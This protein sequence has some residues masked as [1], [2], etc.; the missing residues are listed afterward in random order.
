[1]KSQ[2][3]KKDASRGGKGERRDKKGDRK[4]TKKKK[5]KKSREEVVSQASTADKY[6]L[7]QQAVQSPTTKDLSFFIKAFQL[8]RGRDPVVMREGMHSSLRYPSPLSSLPFLSRPSPLHPFFLSPSSLT[9][10]QTSVEQ[11][12]FQLSG[13]NQMQNE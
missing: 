13:S 4:S 1:M 12:F 9:L 8:Y 10:Y 2:A 3:K 6:S 11:L 5:K 7:Y